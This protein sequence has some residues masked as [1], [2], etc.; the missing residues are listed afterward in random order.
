MADAAKRIWQGIVII[1]ALAAAVALVWGDSGQR[2]GEEQLT[3]E[4]QTQATA[5]GNIIPPP[6]YAIL[7][8]SD[9]GESAVTF[10]DGLAAYREGRYTDAIAHFQSARAKGLT[11]P[12]VAYFLGVSLLM[13]KEAP[14]ASTELGNVIAEGK[15]PFVGDAHYFRAKALLQLGLVERARL[16]L[17]NAIRVLKPPMQAGAI[18]L[19]DSLSG[20]R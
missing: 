3:R 1:A 7:A 11:H 13:N 12:A 10:N 4:A 20:I 8:Y 9:T 6:G 16:E 14:M 19:K 17:D 15:S 2:P 5:L 18:A